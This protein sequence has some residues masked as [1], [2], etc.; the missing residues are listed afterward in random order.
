MWCH[1]PCGMSNIL[2]T[3][4][5]CMSQ[6]MVHCQHEAMSILCIFYKV[7][8]SI[9][10]RVL[11][12]TSLCSFNLSAAP[13]TLMAISNEAKSL[14]Q[15]LLEH[16]IIH[17]SGELLY[18]YNYIQNL[19]LSLVENDPLAKKGGSMISNS[20]WSLKIPMAT[21]DDEQEV[22][23]KIGIAQREGPLGSTYTTPQCPEISSSWNRSGSSSRDRSQ[24]N[25]F[26]STSRK[27]THLG[28]SFAAR[29]THQQHGSH[30][31][32]C[33]VAPTTPFS[34]LGEGGECLGI[35]WNSFIIHSFFLFFTKRHL[36][37]RQHSRAYHPSWKVYATSQRDSGSSQFQQ[38]P[39]AT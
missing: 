2:P 18:N 12:T 8:T 9:W 16:A 22:K 11:Y 26:W 33:T 5:L 7:A 35:A 3:F 39:S 36:S 37:S 31:R 15:M 19:T 13:I 27:H 14:G 20:E 34:P 4:V 23:G 30:L 38:L 32:L 1:R 24:S 10:C 17:T 29:T 28:W 25:N 21:T 6:W